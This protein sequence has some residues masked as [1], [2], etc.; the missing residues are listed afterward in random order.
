MNDQSQTK[1]YRDSF[2]GIL[3]LWTL[4]FLL[5]IFA[6][7]EQYVTNID[8]FTYDVY[9]LFKTMFPLFL[10]YAL[11]SAVLVRIIRRAG[12]KLYL[13]GIVLSISVLM[14]L[15]VQGTFF[16]GNL[17]PLDGRTI[18]WSVYD[19]QRVASVVI[20]ICVLA[21]SVAAVKLLG[22]EKFN[23]IAGC[24]SAFL[25]TVLLVSGGI[26]LI[27][28]EGLRDKQDVLI[29]DDHILE[30]SDQ[31]SNFVILVLDCIGGKDL[32]EIV[33]S[34][35][36]YAELLKDFTNFRNTVGAYPFTQHSIPFIL[37]GEW[38]ENEESFYAYKDRVYK[39]SE[40]FEELRNAGYHIG[41]YEED[42]PTSGEITGYFENTVIPDSSAF[43]EPIEFIKMQM[44]L[45][46]LK[47]M[48]Y[49]LKRCC[50][51]APDYLYVNSLK[52]YED[53]D[54]Y[55]W[56]NL[57]F[58]TEVTEN[59]VEKTDGKCF[60][61]IHI[62]GAHDPFVYDRDMNVVESSS[63]GE[64]IEGSLRCAAEY[65]NNL[66]AAGCYENTA[67]IIMAD[68]G[69]Y[70]DTRQNPMLLV[71]GMNEDHP[72]EVSDIPVSYEDLLPAY[73][74][75]MNGKAAG[76]IFEWKAGDRRDRR[77]LEY[78]FYGEDHM[79]EY[80]QSGYASDP[81]TF[82]PTGREYIRQ[83]EHITSHS[84]FDW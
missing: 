15:Y 33:N 12:K 79:Y 19:G 73:S 43:N 25:F 18:D 81:E 56:T 38:Y 53:L 58:Y 11:V 4:G 36:G 55:D 16:S 2:S 77:Y 41:V 59:S 62:S 3:I 35:P 37:S 9:D 63:Y 68:H 54:T 28:G 71:K 57:A 84:F 13:A 20:W 83:G 45:A 24:C 31:D 40:L 80:I 72:Y 21:A 60:R 67:I 32:E 6:P 49:D 22:F 61:F 46:G 66:K 44:K 69:Y 78:L 14:A 34:N 50:I 82:R 64:C 47:Y 70:K 8:G 23:R 29:T 30:M 27:T 74:G 26:L 65:L 48:P 75:L 39:D 42:L 76:E 17:P 1:K 52:R 10:I 7:M 51:V 5:F